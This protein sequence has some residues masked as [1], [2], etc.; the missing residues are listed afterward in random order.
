MHLF[1][2]PALKR[3]QWL[4]V[5]T[6]FFRGVAAG[7]ANA[8]PVVPG[9][10]T[11]GLQP[12]LNTF[13]LGIPGV[14]VPLDMHRPGDGRQYIAAISG[15]VIVSTGGAES[16]FLD[17]AEHPDVPFT[18]NFAG[19]LMS[20]VFH[21]GYLTPES[22]GY[23]KFYTFSSD[24]K[25][26]NQTSSA[27]TVT[28]G[29]ELT[30]LPDFWHPEMYAPATGGNPLTNWTNPNSP[31][32]GNTDFDHF[33]VI[34]EW[35]ATADG[36]T[37]DANVPPRVVLRMAHGFQ[38]K[39]S[40]NGGSMRF[41]PDGHMYFV[42]GD[43]GG[44]SGQ[45]HDGGINNG[46]D[47]HTDGTG[48]A[49]DRTVVYGKVLRIDPTA[50][51]KNSANGQYGIP[52]DNPYVLDESNPTFLDEIYAYGFRH[53]WKINF[54]DRPGGDGS[55]YLADVGQHHREEID[56]I[57]AGGN[58]GWGYLEGNVR[59]VSQDSATG[60]PDPNDS[61]D[62]TNG[63]PV[64]VPP[65]GYENFDSTPPLVDYLTRRQ[66]VGG[67]LVGDGTAVTGGFVYRG[68]GIPE[69]EGMYV[70]GDYSIAGSPP[71]GLPA[72]KGR[73]FYVDPA[74]P[75]QIFEFGI[76]FGASDMGQLLGFG[77]DDAGELYALFDNGNVVRLVGLPPGDFDQDGDIDADDLNDPVVGW[78]ARFGADLDGADFLAWQRNLGVGASTVASAAVPEPAVFALSL[79]A[80]ALLDWQGAVRRPKAMRHAHARRGIK[81]AGSPR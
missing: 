71:P 57:T 70:F 41:G 23:H 20:V 67:Q 51:V 72:N 38:G 37:I 34:R 25:T 35:T 58:Y 19:G 65:E 64:R 60:E 27:A 44:N 28:P 69:L 63:T 36:L 6:A 62:G 50:A 61:I 24:W 77:D 5:S 52:A 26:T 49:Q 9:S 12:V 40:H 79:W 42:T 1:V 45:D 15:Q 4:S 78:K 66:N 43:G 55:L 73:L 39:G 33:N 59:L 54:D 17:L 13:S 47:G 22:H 75:A 7:G 2:A 76:A 53:A 68:A 74:D 10:I 16:L 14:S 29:N 32:A 11:I 21:P 80:T 3:L 30:G 56:V 81:S 31:S 46:E 8:Q 48:N 18:S